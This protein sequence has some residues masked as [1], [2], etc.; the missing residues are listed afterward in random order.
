MA[1][2]P[3]EVRDGVGLTHL[4]QELLAGDDDHPAVS[5][6]AVVD[7]LDAVADR[8][9]P[10]LA[11]RPLSVVRARGTERFMQKNLP[12][13]APDWIRSVTFWSESSQRDVR[14]ALVE[15][16]ATLLWFANQRAVEY[17]VP[18]TLADAPGVPTHL[19]LDLDPPEGSGLGPVVT[20]ARAVREVLRDAGFDPAVKT[21]GAKGLHVVTP[22]EHAAMEDVH[23][24][25][26]AVAARAERLDP[27]GTT[28]A[29]IKADRGGKVFLDATRAGGAT[30]VAAYSP[31]VRPGLPVSCPCDWDSLD[32]V[33]PSE[34]T[35]ATPDRFL[36]GPTWQERLGEAM[37]IPADLVEEGHTIPVARVAAMHE[38]KRRKRAASRDDG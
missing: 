17:H 19:V 21:S 11:N 31:R 23:A 14:Y 15:D 34:I 18:L 28:T 4:D 13:G 22:I 6:R 38:G 8:M 5:K 24:A 9:L 32:E 33:V 16:R 7:H 3:D 1:S 35:V 26:R 20:A 29:F 30:V 37:A 36:R 27:G 25:T 2:D 10:L 12:K